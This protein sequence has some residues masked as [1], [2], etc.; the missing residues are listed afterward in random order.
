MMYELVGVFWN[1]IVVGLTG[2]AVLSALTIWFERKATARVQRRVGPLWI[3]RPIGGLLQ[4]LADLVR[5]AFQT[6]VIPRE[7]HV[8]VFVLLP[9]LSFVTSIF[10]L[11]VLPMTSVEVYAPL[12]S[13]DFT[14]LLAVAIMVLSSLTIIA[15]GWASGNK[16]AMI[17]S[18]R[19]SYILITY[20]VLILASVITAIALVGSFDAI[21]VVEFQKRYL[22]LVLLNPLGFLI[23]LLAIML[24]SSTFPF[25]I[26]ESESEVVAG[27]YTEFSG[28]LYV[29]SMASVYVKRYTYSIITSIVYLG[30]WTPLEPQ[31]GLLSGLVMPT[32]VVSAKAVPI[33]FLMSFM[34]SVYGRLRLDQALDL[35]WRVLVPLALV[36]IAWSIFLRFILRGV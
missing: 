24:A 34:R 9:I 17:G 14:L 36:A 12:S 33:M 31:E 10:P 6:P 2:S 32:L 7:A 21:E 30:G 19:E 16:F 18:L 27:P 1:V 22:W 11:F 23:L 29:F 35:A 26:A 28:L 5:I 15:M 25:E 3:S 13:T 4:P 20:E 8:A